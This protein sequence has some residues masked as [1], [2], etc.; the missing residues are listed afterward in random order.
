MIALEVN[1]R[2]YEIDVD[3]D[4]P[5]LWAIRDGIGLT[6][7]KYGC[8]IAMCGA[9]TVHVDGKAVRSCSMPVSAAVGRRV[10]TIENVAAS[11][12]GKAVQSAW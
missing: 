6:G 12:V 11:R 4:T 10:T 2:K 3:P 7:T 1:G 8:G 5:L 9:C